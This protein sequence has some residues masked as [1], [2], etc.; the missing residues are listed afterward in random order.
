MTKPERI[1]HAGIPKDARAIGEATSI[2]DAAWWPC[3]QPEDEYAI[4]VS[5][6]AHLLGFDQSRPMWVKMIVGPDSSIIGPV[7]FTAYNSSGR[8]TV[9]VEEEQADALALW[10]YRTFF[11]YA[12]LASLESGG[13]GFGFAPQHRVIFP[14]EPD[15]NEQAKP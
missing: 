3:A 1:N 11:M 12:H 15:F 8:G 4:A 7:I 5:V 6:S 10:G 9:Q 14:D 2:E 13:E